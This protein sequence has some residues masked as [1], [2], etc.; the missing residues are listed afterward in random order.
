MR[1]TKAQFKTAVWNM[2]DQPIH[3]K[4]FIKMYEDELD[5]MW[6]KPSRQEIETRAEMY[7][8]THSKVL[9]HNSKLKKHMEQFRK[10]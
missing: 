1:W 5:G 8:L 2:L 3:Y 4:D 10:Q 9:W 7:E 6:K